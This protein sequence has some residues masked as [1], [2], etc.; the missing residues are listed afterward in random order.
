M[1][2]LRWVFPGFGV[3]GLVFWAI[4]RPWFP[5]PVIGFI[6]YGAIVAV[7]TVGT[8]W[9]MYAAVRFE[10]N[11]LP[12]ILL[13]FVPFTSLWYYFER[14]KPAKYGN[15]SI[16]S[17]IQRQNEVAA[18]PLPSRHYVRTGLY[19]FISLCALS[20][21]LWAM[22]P[23]FPQGS[24]VTILVTVF[25]FVLPPIGAF[26]MI[27]TAIRHENTPFPLVLLAC[28]PYAFLWYYFERVRTG[29]SSGLPQ[30]NS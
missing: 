6:L 21:A 5:S 19:G 2:V 11:P 12:F 22:S 7:A 10:K 24:F 16:A 8:F 30:I 26:W 29:K 25:G 1:R 17:G 20:L 13:A 28:L 23:S 14:I 15:D 9:M 4:T 18:H 27:Y 3:T